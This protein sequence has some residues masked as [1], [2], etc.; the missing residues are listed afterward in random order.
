MVHRRLLCPYVGTQH[1][2]LKLGAR[3]RGAPMRLGGAL[4]GWGP[5]QPVSPIQGPR[6]CRFDST[7]SWYAL[8]IEL[9]LLLPEDM[10]PGFL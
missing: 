10:G 4:S 9:P 6:P 5:H 7:R 2:H 3:F 8:E 1:T